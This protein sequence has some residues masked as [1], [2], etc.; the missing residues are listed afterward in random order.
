MLQSA[1][2][3]LVLGSD[4]IRL[5]KEAAKLYLEMTREGRGPKVAVFSGGKGRLTPQEWP[6]TEADIKSFCS[7]T[8]D[9]SFPMFAK[10]DVNGP[11]AH[12]LYQELKAAQKGLLGSEGIKWNFTKFLVDREGNVVG[13]FGSMDK[14]ES[15]RKKIEAIL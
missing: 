12:P 14:P 2:V 10:V 7:L 8:Y 1:D 13:R 6:G 4:D 11:E 9:V 3:L 5:P 15:L